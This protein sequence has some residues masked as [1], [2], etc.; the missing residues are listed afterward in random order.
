MFKFITLCSYHVTY[1]FQSES[2]L[3]SCLN[4]REL[5]ARNSGDI[6]RNMCN[7]DSFEQG[8]P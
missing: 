2:T 8:V 3:Y 6:R 5:L 1:V 7:V 4:V